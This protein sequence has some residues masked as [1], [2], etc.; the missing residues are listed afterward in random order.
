MKEAERISPY[1]VAVIMPSNSTMLVAPL[2]DIPAHTCNFGGCL[3]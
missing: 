3:W 2:L 1:L